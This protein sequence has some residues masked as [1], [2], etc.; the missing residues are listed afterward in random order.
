MRKKIK[1][2]LLAAAFGYDSLLDRQGWRWIGK[3]LSSLPS[4]EE[5]VGRR[6]MWVD[7]LSNGK[8][9]DIGCG[10]GEFLS[11]MRDLGWEVLGTEPDIQAAK[12]VQ[13]QFHV[14]VIV[15]TLEKAN[16]PDNFF[17]VVTMNHVIEHVHDPIR[18]LRE[19]WRILKPRGKLVVV[20][21]N[22]ESLGHR[23]FRES[24]GPLEPPRHLHLFSLQ[25]V[26]ACTEGADLRIETLRTTARGA[27]W[28]W[29][30]SKLIRRDGRFSE[31]NIN[32]RLRIESFIF[33][34]VEGVICVL[35]PSSGE[36]LVL[37][38]VKGA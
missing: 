36:E 32:G 16:L 8:L 11:M 18:L 25:T 34:V 29:K 30:A 4:L 15:G 13:D 17:D 19:C 9:L 23:A 2:A 7:W 12:I 35:W 3:V 20:T 33:Q 31:G 21:P 27:R 26:R 38:G 14:P 22:I 28:M 24:W 5:R 6:I 1:H 37:I 10:N